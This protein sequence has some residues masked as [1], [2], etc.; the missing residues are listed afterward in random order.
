M[1]RPLAGLMVCALGVLLGVPALLLIGA[2]IFTMSVMYKN[3]NT[4]RNTQQEEIKYGRNYY[5]YKK[6]KI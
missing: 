4:R 2:A 6:R 1:Y 3:S 5:D